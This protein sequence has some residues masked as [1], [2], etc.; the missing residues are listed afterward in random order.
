MVLTDEQL[1]VRIR[2]GI[3][4]MPLNRLLGVRVPRLGNGRAAAELRSVDSVA[5]HAGG[6]HAAAQYALVEAA[7]GAAATTAFAGLVGRAIPLAQRVE[8]SYRRAPQGGVVAEALVD[9]D[10][11]ERARRLVAEGRDAAFSV[12]CELT[13][14][15]GE[16]VGAAV[17]RWILR[18][19]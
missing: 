8:L 4:A 3:E 7:C 13:D 6:V 17:M 9:P 10:E 15:G 5:N 1:A 18:V 11:A 12:V 19:S 2:Q 14:A 16:V